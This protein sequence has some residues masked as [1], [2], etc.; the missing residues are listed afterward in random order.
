MVK[1]HLH[2]LFHLSILETSEILQAP[3]ITQQI[4]RGILIP[5]YDPPS[6]LEDTVD[7]LK[8]YLFYTSPTYVKTFDN[9]HSFILSSKYMNEYNKANFF[10]TSLVRALYPTLSDSS[11]TIYGPALV[12]GMNEDTNYT[13]VSYS[14]LDATVNLMSRYKYEI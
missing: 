14:L 5:M 11:L 9:E 3:I 2:Q 12:V 7:N 8:R 4:C 10:A 1:N 13:S 6:V